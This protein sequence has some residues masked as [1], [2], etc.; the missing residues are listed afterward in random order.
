MAMN[1]GVQKKVQE[2]LDAVVGR[3]RLPTFGDRE[4]LRYVDAVLKETIRWHPPVP[5]GIAH[6]AM[7]D[8]YYDGL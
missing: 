3:N 7:E 5:I 2:E 6:R 4:A 8:E 1:P